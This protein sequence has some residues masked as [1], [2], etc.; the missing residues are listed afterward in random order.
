VTRLKTGKRPTNMA[1]RGRVG[2]GAM[3]LALIVGYFAYIGTF[4][5]Y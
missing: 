3:L 2:W 4:S 5:S 1:G